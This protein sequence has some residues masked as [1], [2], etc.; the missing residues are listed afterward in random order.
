MKTSLKIRREA[1]RLSLLIALVLVLVSAVLTYRAWAAFERNRQEAQ[2]TRQVVDG[3]TALLSSLKDAEAGQ[4]GF[5]LT[6]SDLYL[7]PYRH[8][9]AEIPANLDA[10]ARLESGR[11]PVQLRRVETLKPLVRAKMDELAQTI[12]LRRSQGLDPALAIV[13]TD[14]GK[15][16]MDRIRAICAE[17]Q[18]ASYDLLGQQREQ[19]RASAYQAGFTSII[20]SSIVFVLLALA[21]ISIRKGTRHRLRL[22]ED[23]QRSEEQAK[24]ARDLLQHWRWRYHHRRRRE[25][26]LFESGRPVLDRVDTGTGGG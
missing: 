11:D 3:T 21:T 7:E 17:I 4:R 13:R 5:L 9:L 24:E 26:R 12:E 19:V 2:L 16:A 6:G 22:I 23:L 18:T 15:A 25:D 14:R 1:E 10:L 8:A 20:G